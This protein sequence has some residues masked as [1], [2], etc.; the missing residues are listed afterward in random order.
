MVLGSTVVSRLYYKIT[1]TM[2]KISLA[3]RRIILT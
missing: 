3:T 1:L 2:K